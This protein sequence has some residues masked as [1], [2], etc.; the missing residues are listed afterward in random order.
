M[1]IKTTRVSNY[2]A[3]GLILLFWFSA[4][5]NYFANLGHIP[6][7][8]L[9]P[10]LLIQLALS[11]TFVTIVFVVVFMLLGKEQPRDIGFRHE[12]LGQQL[13]IGT[14]FD[15]TLALFEFFAIGC[16]LTLYRRCTLKREFRMRIIQ[17]AAS[18]AGQI[19]I[20]HGRKIYA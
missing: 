4:F 1:I 11:N 12:R 3:I 16:R 2:V 5:S 10:S 18:Y 6:K 20:G 9:N 14:G 17:T 19:S 7:I 13:L 15:L 8:D